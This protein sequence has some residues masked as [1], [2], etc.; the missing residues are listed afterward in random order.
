MLAVLGEYRGGPAFWLLVAAAVYFVVLAVRLSAA[1]ILHHRL[2]NALVLPAY[3]VAGLLLAGS[4]LAAGEPER[5]AGAGAGAVLLWG[6]Y[7]LLRLF[8]PAGMGFGDV[9]LAGVLGLYLGF[10]G[11]LQVLAGTAAAFVAGGIW[12]LALI[13]SGR[14]TGQT[15]VPFGP[16]ML[17]GAAVAL[18][19]PVLE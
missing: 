14:G 12:G 13:V 15:A 19:L 16:F 2:P 5:I 9:K 10:A 11:W 7:F 3:P 6:A 18:A 17:A 8:N 1:D 4:A